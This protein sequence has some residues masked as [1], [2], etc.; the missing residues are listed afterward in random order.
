MPRARSG[1]RYSAEPM[2]APAVVSEVS[3]VVLRDAEVGEQDLAVARRASRSPAS[4]RGARSRRRAPR[5]ARRSSARRPAVVRHGQRA[6]A[7][8]G[9]RPAS[10]PATSCITIQGASSSTTTSCT[11]TMFGWSRSR[12]ALRASRSA[13]LQPVGRRR[14]RRHEGQE[15]SLTATSMRSA[16]SEA[17]QTRPMPPEPSRAR[18]RYRPPTSCPGSACPAMRVPPDQWFVSSSGYVFYVAARAYCPRS[19]S[20]VHPAPDGV[21]PSERSRSLRPAPVCGFPAKVERV[22]VRAGPEVTR[23]TPGPPGNESRG[24]LVQNDERVLRGR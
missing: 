10:C 24:T 8:I 15:T 6:V 19:Q 23:T 17:R 5:P 2:T 3:C 18:R 16:S 4:R 7:S 13:R 12:A 9:A 1:A 22:T 14:A 21:R 11:A 20:R